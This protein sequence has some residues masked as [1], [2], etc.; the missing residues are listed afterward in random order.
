MTPR[1]MPKKND[2]TVIGM[3]IMSLVSAFD[4]GSL[5]V[6]QFFV[7]VDDGVARDEVSSVEVDD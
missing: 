6:G 3:M 4:F 2:K 7:E 1:A 5:G